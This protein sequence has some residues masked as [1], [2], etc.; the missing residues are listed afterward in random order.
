MDYINDLQVYETQ[1]YSRLPY[2]G[3]AGEELYLYPI[4]KGVTYANNK[5]LL[6][7]G[8]IS[9]EENTLINVKEEK[10]GLEESAIT[11]SQL[12]TTD[13]LQTANNQPVPDK[14]QIKI[15]DSVPARI[16]MSK[17]ELLERQE[18]EK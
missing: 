1:H 6:L 5:G 17:Q 13:R 7:E 15:F 14:L 10:E 2:Y 18:E 4:T 12:S 8:D 3:S 16:R 9:D 11:A